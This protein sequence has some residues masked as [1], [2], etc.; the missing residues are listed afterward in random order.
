MQNLSARALGQVRTSRR[1]LEVAAALRLAE[2]LVAHEAA[3]GLREMILKM[4]TQLEQLGRGPRAHGADLLLSTQRSFAMWSLCQTQPGFAGLR[5]VRECVAYGPRSLEWLMVCSDVIRLFGEMA[6]NPWARMVWG[7]GLGSMA[8]KDSLRPGPVFSKPGPND[9]G[10]GHRDRGDRP[11]PGQ[12]QDPFAY[13]PRDAVAWRGVEKFQFGDRSTIGVI[14]YTYGLPIE[15]ADVSGTTADSIAALRWANTAL[16]TANTLAVIRSPRA[17]NP[18]AQLIA[19]ATMVPQGHH[20]IIECAWPLTRH[21]YIDYAIGFYDTLAPPGPAHDELR[22]W[23][24]PLNRDP[25]NQH[26]LVSSD[27]NLLF[28][29]PDEVQAYR[30]IAGIRRAYAFCAGGKTN[31]KGLQNLLHAHGV[32]DLV[33]DRIAYWVGH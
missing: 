14:D 30:K 8:Q 22:Q 17:A 10:W 12:V 20:T 4:L 18:A 19:I 32:N 3:L 33:T 16:R 21:G 13:I 26:V 24:E 9:E 29:K 31:A 7:A 11:N 1:E 25:R 5:D 2:Y 27:L 28:E 23:L 6:E 15:G